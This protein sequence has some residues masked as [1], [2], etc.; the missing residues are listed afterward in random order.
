VNLLKNTILIEQAQ[1]LVKIMQSK[2]KLTTLC[3]LSRNK[4]TLDFSAQELGPGD[5]VLIANDISD[6]GAMTKFNISSN[7]LRAEGGKAL[8]AGLKG[9]QVITELN[10]SDNRLGKNKL[11]DNVTSGVNA[12]ADAIPGMGAISTLTFG[13]KQ[14]VTM[15]TEMAEANFSGKLYSYEAQVVAAFLPKCT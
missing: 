3:G 2:E 11:L 8:A 9:N 15:T 14:A 4:A 5:A 10:I 1:E 7:D 12:I 13:D 6:M